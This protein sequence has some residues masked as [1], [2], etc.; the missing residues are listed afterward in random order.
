M[1][2]HM[3]IGHTMFVPSDHSKPIKIGEFIFNFEHVILPQVEAYC[4]IGNENDLASIFT[5]NIINNY[6]NR[7]EITTEDFISLINVTINENHST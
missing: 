6:L 5:P 7:K 4:G 2:P 1:G 3:Q